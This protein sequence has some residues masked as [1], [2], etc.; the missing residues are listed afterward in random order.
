MGITNGDVCQV[1]RIEL[2]NNPP[3]PIPA[4]T[5]TGIMDFG[6]SGNSGKAVM[7]TANQSISDLSTYGMGSANNGGG[8]DGQEYTFP[9]VSV[10]AGEHIVICRDQAALSSYFAGCLEQFNGAL[11][12]TN[13][14]ENSSFPDGNGDDAYE[15]FHN[16]AVIE[17]FGDI[18]TQVN[19]YLDSWAWKDTASA[20][21][22]N[23]VYGG[24]NCSDNSS[25]TQT[26]NCPFPLA[27]TACVATYDV[28]LK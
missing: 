9:A 19:T 20:N 25:S 10:S 3:A 22:G 21:V 12:P 26:S 27:T 11:F 7:L 16:G 13:I 24:N 6:L 15:L 28:T 23:W 14:I 1:Q 4:L 8:T 18:N 17:T 2:Y 5:L